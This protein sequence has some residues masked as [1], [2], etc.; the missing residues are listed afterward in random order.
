MR[1][2]AI[3]LALFAA[4]SYATHLDTDDLLS[5]LK[6]VHASEAR[7]IVECTDF[8]PDIVGFA[9]EETRSGIALRR[10]VLER[11]V[12]IFERMMLTRYGGAVCYAIKG[13]A[14][15]SPAQLPK[16]IE[17][18]V[19]YRELFSEN[20]GDL[21]YRTCTLEV[22][23]EHM[24]EHEVQANEETWRRAW[25][26]WLTLV[27]Q[28]GAMA[29]DHRIVEA[30]SQRL[31][32]VPALQE[33]D[34]S[35]AHEYAQLLVLDNPASALRKAVAD[36]PD[37]TTGEL[38][39]KCLA[40][41]EAEGWGEIPLVD[42]GLATKELRVRLRIANKLVE[43]AWD[44]LGREGF[45]T[46]PWVALWLDIHDREALVDHDDETVRTLATGVLDHPWMSPEKWREL[47]DDEAFQRAALIRGAWLLNDSVEDCRPSL[48]C[49]LEI[50][51]KHPRV[52]LHASAW[53]SGNV[54][55]YIADDWPEA[56]MDELVDASVKA[57]QRDDKDSRLAG[58]AFLA[59]L[60]E[61]YAG[62]EESLTEFG[63]W[64]ISNSANF[65]AA[66]KWAL[67]DCA[68]GL[69]PLVEDDEGALAIW[70]N[71]AK[72]WSI[73][74]SRELVNNPKSMLPVH[75]PNLYEGFW[76]FP[77]LVRAEALL[78]AVYVGWNTFVPYGE[79][80]EDQE[81]DRSAT[82]IYGRMKDALAKLE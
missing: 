43:M 14:E 58:A 34:A 22:L 17:H 26:R 37:T 75:D 11:D 15:L 82:V 62:R 54:F 79:V 57:A 3:L 6:D 40:W 5:G 66:E 55:R 70:K 39:L 78:R 38:A 51:E 68:L 76:A 52:L 64:I 73:E 29:A 16:W 10:L 50:L 77:E 41:W 23:L 59:E 49:V 25:K 69:R 12:S 74:L 67:R 32:G 2:L 18:C 80:P 1:Y 53:E 42:T 48:R 56:A 65:A 35:A 47:P 24:K 20:H 46:H 4:P 61:H 13:I 7:W 8:E 30:I 28:E 33:E 19:G 9:A 36:G 21:G 81:D 44:F 72:Q 60:D 45:E 63:H 31:G 71:A 27:R